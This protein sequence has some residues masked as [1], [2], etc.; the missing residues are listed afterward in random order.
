M[1]TCY[2]RVLRRDEL[3]AASGSEPAEDSMPNAVIFEKGRVSMSSEEHV[4]IM[5]R[6]FTE[7]WRGDVTMADDIFSPELTTNGVAV[8]IEGPKR[9]IASRLSGFPDVQ[10]V[11]EDEIADGD[12]VLLRIVWRGTHTGAYS[13][14]PPTGKPVEVRG[15]S[16]WRFDPEGKV[17]EIWSIQDQFSLLQQIGAISP[18]LVGAQLPPEASSTDHPSD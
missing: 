3:A 18:D 11:I 7:G 5:R 9:N 12:K 8:G 4:A 2:R 15:L 14:I 10:A 13:G 6:W 1:P 17:A 16:L